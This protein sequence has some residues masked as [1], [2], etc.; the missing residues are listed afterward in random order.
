[1][2]R[3]ID[4]LLNGPHYVRYN[5]LTH[6]LDGSE[7]DEEVIVSRKKMILNPKVRDLIEQCLDWPGPVLKRHNDAK[8]LIHKLCFLSEIGLNKSDPAIDEI[9]RKVMSDQDPEGPFRI[10]THL[11]ERFG[12][13][14]KDEMAW[15]LCDAPTVVYSLA[16]LGYSSDKRVLK[17]RDHLISLMDENGWRCHVSE[18]LGRMRGP[19]GKELECPY[20]TLLMLKLISAYPELKD[21]K[22]A[23]T[24][25]SVILN[26]WTERKKRKP[27]LFAMGT[28]FKKL[29][30]PMIW[31][32]ILHVTEVLSR[33]GKA[34]KDERL[35]EMYDLIIPKADENGLYTPESV[36][37]AWKGWDFSQKKE[38]S[39]W[40]TFRIKNI[41]H[42]MNSH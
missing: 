41:Q 12:G 25:I 26:L 14:G 23:E 28:D 20:S 8:L 33:F 34:R 10:Y 40:L 42:R 3:E 15:F 1:M 2:E 39:S 5:T 24:G 32:D 17:A 31:Y 6:L 9:A 11:Y 22:E 35:K 38:P 7:D 13:S 21:G 4:L 29:K 27:F 37:M 19:G 30:L 18:E 16:K 36:W